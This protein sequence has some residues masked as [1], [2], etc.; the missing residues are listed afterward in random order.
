MRSVANGITSGFVATVPMTAVMLLSKEVLRG[1]GRK[2][3]PPQQ[4][5]DKI[6]N[7]SDL[8]VP[9][10]RHQ[11]LASLSHFGFGAAAGAAY[12]PLKKWL[13][14]PPAAKGTIFGAL[15]WSISYGALLP[16]LRL[17]PQAQDQPRGRNIA[18]ILAHLVWGASLGALS[19]AL[20]ASGTD[21]GGSGSLP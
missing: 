14:G 11:V 21:L 20:N 2:S 16:A 13:P 1:H 5:T 4:I 12:E 6:V 7:R 17:Q 19:S 3:V 8:P 18:M 15:V 9:G 10:L